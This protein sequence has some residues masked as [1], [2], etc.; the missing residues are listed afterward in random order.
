MDAAI[1]WLGERVPAVGP[2]DWSAWSYWYAGGTNEQ[3]SYGQWTENGCAV[4]CGPVAWAM[5]I[6]WVDRRATWDWRWRNQRGMY[7]QNG[8]YGTDVM[9]PIGQDYGVYQI[10]RELRSRLGTWCIT[11]SGATW[12]WDMSRASGYLAYRSPGYVRTFYNAAGVAD[13]GCS[14]QVEASIKYLGTPAIMGTGWLT[15]YP[16][17]FIFA[18]RQQQVLWWT[19]Y[20]KWVWVNQGWWG[21]DN[22]WVD[23]GSW[24]SGEILP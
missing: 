11:G 3:C 14:A 7:R 5:L 12:P 13:A 6:G 18:Q 21:Y 1:A 23:A 17:G 20:Q 16:L 8:G 10:I 19:E 24:F 9:A 4:G 2:A 15:H 22:T